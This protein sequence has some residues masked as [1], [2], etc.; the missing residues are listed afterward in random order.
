MRH[1]REA[2][3][4]TVA[5]WAMF[6][7]A[8]P[9]PPAQAANKEHQQLMA[10]LRILQE[11]TQQLQV[12]LNALTEALKAVSARMD[13]Q[14]GVTRKAF[15]DQRLLID[16]LTGDVRVVR[17]KLDE[18]NVRLSSLSQEV[19]AVRQTAAAAAA[20]AARPTPSEDQPQ[21]MQEAAPPPLAP[22]PA[23]SGMSPQRLY[24]TAYADYSA[25]QWSLAIQGFEAFIKSFPRAEQADDAQ[26]YVGESYL[27]DNKLEQAI[28][29]YDK[30]IADYPAG[31]ATPMAYYKRGLVHDKLGRPERARESWQTVIQKFP[32]SDAALLAKQGLDRL[33]RPN[34]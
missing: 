19:D 9:A 14:A 31:D 21:D 15:A 5:A 10:D 16:T 1:R 24:D 26:L 22:S 33:A 32:T 6:A 8:L 3:I 23:A 2:S 7:L 17:E 25:G 11:Q 12:T 30:T 18:T 27:L 20:A 4:L 13:D 28:A 29:A 34:R